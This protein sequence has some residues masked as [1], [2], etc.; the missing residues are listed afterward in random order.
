MAMHNI[1]GAA[2]APRDPF[3]GEPITPCPYC[4]RESSE[5]YDGNGCCWQCFSLLHGLDGGAD[6]EQAEDAPPADLEDETAA[7]A[8]VPD[9]PFDVLDGPLAGLV[10]AADRAGLPAALAAGAGVAAVAAAIGGR[11]SVTPGGDWTERAIAWVPL[12]GP[13]G[14]GKSPVLAAAFMPLW[15]LDA[16]RADRPSL[17]FDD[18][19]LEAVARELAAGGGAAAVCADELASWL[20]GLG[21]YKRGG[22]ADRARLLALWSGGPW[23]M[24]RVGGGGDKN[25]VRLRIAAPTMPIVGGLQPH[26]HE[27]LGGESDGMRPRWLPHLAPL[28]AVPVAPAPC[29]PPAAWRELLASLVAVRDRERSWRLDRE[30]ARSFAQM[31]AEWRQRAR[32][33]GTP[34]TVGAALD[35]AAVHVLRVALVLAEAGAPGRGGAVDAATLERAAAII[36]YATACWAALPEGPG[37]ALSRH[38]ATC[39]EAC[40]AIAAW[41]EARGGR[42][43]RG[44]LLRAHVGGVRASVDLSA[45]L[46]RYEQRYP[47]CVRAVPAGARGGRPGVVV[48]APPRRPAGVYSHA[49]NKGPCAE[50]ERPENTGDDGPEGGLLPRLLPRESGNKPGGVEPDP[51]VSDIEEVLFARF[52]GAP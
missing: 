5:N 41:L 38:D 39:D 29:E 40:E 48:L 8:E 43:S 10:E 16:E 26:L 44:E 30:A 23:T 1:P 27:L 3:A 7:L 31:H 35:K 34:P 6:D 33:P 2:D 9:Y 47:G 11:S 46:R 24:R 21:C 28:A 13:R 14:C 22:G 17:T 15:Q 50:A 52:G 51:D 12:I 25:Q 37:L 4:G 19:T 36:E 49:A 42:A 45:V 20:E 18:A 32:D